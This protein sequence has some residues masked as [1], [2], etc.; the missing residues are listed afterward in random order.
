LARCGGADDSIRAET[1][2][3]VEQDSVLQAHRIR[4]RGPAP[5]AAD[6]TESSTPHVRARAR[7]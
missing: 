3:R 1:S 4:T 7:P 6:R 5:D 2:D